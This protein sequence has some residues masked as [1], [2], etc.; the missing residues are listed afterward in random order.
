DL[1][2]FLA[3][4][5]PGLRDVGTV[6][7]FHENQFSYPL[8][9]GT[10][11]DLT[12]GF[13]NLV[14]AWVADRVLFNSRFHLEEF[15][16]AACEV[17]EKMPDED[18]RW[19]L[20][21]VRQKSDVLP[22]G[23]DLRRLDRYRDQGYQD[24]KAG[25]WGNPALGPL[26]VWNQRWEYDKAPEA[27]FAALNEVKAAGVRFRLAVAGKEGSSENG[28]ELF[29]A[30]R[31]QLGEVVVHWGEIKEESAYASLLW[32]ADVVVSSAIHEFFGVAVVEAIYCGCRPVLPR[33]LSYPELVPEEVHDR[34]LYDEGELTTTLLRVLSNPKEWSCDWQ[35]TWVARYDWGSIGQRYDEEIANVWQRRGQYLGKVRY[36]H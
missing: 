30:A 4:L 36:R 28:R 13:R 16:S 18:P 24:A 10:E 5:E 20:E 27:L 32:A 15:F 29:A 17:L 19:L 9:P 31:D 3:G 7:Y 33:R 2:T 23:C 25:R 6:L 11:R 34:V 12:Y 14:S 22:L 1:P 21:E 26:V 35:R 8:P